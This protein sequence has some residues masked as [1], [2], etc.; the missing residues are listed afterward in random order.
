MKRLVC[1]VRKN[2]ET[3]LLCITFYRDGAR[4]PYGSI[5]LH[6]F[7]LLTTTSKVG[8]SLRSVLQL[9]RQLNAETTSQPSLPSMYRIPSSRVLRKKNVGRDNWAHP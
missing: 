2:R 3:Y 6:Y 8:S 4:T 1:Y 7:Q 9:F 5:A